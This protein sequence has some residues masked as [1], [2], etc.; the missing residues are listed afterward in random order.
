MNFCS[1]NA[2]TYSDL[3]KI[4]QLKDR[5]V[6]WGRICNKTH[7]SIR[8]GYDFADKLIDLLIPSEYYYFPEIRGEIAY[9][10]TFHYCPEC[11]KQGYHSL[12]SQ[13]PSELTCPIHNI[14]YIDLHKDLVIGMSGEYN[15]FEDALSVD[16]PLP[17]EREPLDYSKIEERVREVIS[18]AVHMGY[19]LPYTNE[20]YIYDKLEEQ[21]AE[22][23]RVLVSVIDGTM[24][25]QDY[26]NKVKEHFC[27]MALKTLTF[28]E[29][30]HAMFFFKNLEDYL[31]SFWNNTFLGCN[32]NIHD[33]LYR[34]EIMACMYEYVKDV[35]RDEWPGLFPYM[36]TSDYGEYP[37]D[38]ETMVKASYCYAVRGN[39][40]ESE[41]FSLRYLFIMG[42]TE[43]KNTFY[44]YTTYL[45]RV[46]NDVHEALVGM[47]AVGELGFD[48]LKSVA[49][50]E[51]I[52]DHFW[53]QAARYEA[54][55]K[56][57]ETFE[58]RKEWRNIKPLSYEFHQNED[59]TLY[60]YRV[61]A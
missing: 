47:S 38:N 11:I 15:V 14:P 28:D 3:R 59:G 18:G 45:D 36:T 17:Q 39:R 29:D 50:V 8:T 12:L 4:W 53:A 6:S 10:P 30:Y 5:N 42:G 31:E 23:K 24:T 37:S 40:W 35:N 20:Y 9:K 52:H 2:L 41:I 61:A 16:L 54:D 55:I 56:S 60:I 58:F 7:C 49:A 33:Y 48:D 27:S 19:S 43:S 22:G 51:V 34:A 21:Y 46:E 25:Y 44:T 13:I 57:R 1:I 26:I 32:Y